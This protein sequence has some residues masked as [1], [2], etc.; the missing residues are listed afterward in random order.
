MQVILFSLFLRILSWPF[1]RCN[2]AIKNYF[3][4]DLYTG[5]KLDYLSKSVH[6]NFN[7]MR[8][9]QYS[10]FKLTNEVSHIYYTKKTHT[11]KIHKKN[12][13]ERKT[14]DTTWRKI[15]PTANQINTLIMC[16]RF[17]LAITYPYTQSSPQHHNVPRSLQQLSPT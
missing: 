17:T 12:Q 3:T 6:K 10:D 4:I 7:I 9:I 16:Q 5:Q 2:P 14:I 13:G 11:K 1:F 8:T 15:I